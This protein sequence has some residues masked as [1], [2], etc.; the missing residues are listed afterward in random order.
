[1]GAQVRARAWKLFSNVSAAATSLLGSEHDRT[2]ANA[3][4]RADRPPLASL[5]EAV[6]HQI[7]FASGAFVSPHTKQLDGSRLTTFWN[8][9]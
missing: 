3:R 1:V 4:L 8:V 9:S 6:A 7:Y 5:I 2:N